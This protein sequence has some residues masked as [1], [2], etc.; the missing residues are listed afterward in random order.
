MAFKLNTSKF[1]ALSRNS[2]F[3]KWLKDTASDLHST[4]VRVRKTPG[5]K[6]N[7]EYMM[8]IYRDLYKRGKGEELET[9][10]KSRFSYLIEKEIEA[11]FPGVPVQT[12][13]KIRPKS[14]KKIPFKNEEMNK[15]KVFKIYKPSMLMFPQKRILMDDSGELLLKLVKKFLS[16][17]IGSDFIIIENRAY[18]EYFDQK[19]ATIN[20]KIK[21]ETRD[22][23]QYRLDKG[24]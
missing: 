3:N 15:H 8:I 1:C 9:F 18:I 16:D 21:K 13:D 20:D 11:K 4:L 7:R 6:S 17:K 19:Y 12:V 23:Y 14:L 24:L 2:D 5:C 10:I 22:I